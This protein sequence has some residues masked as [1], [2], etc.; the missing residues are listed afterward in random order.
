MAAKS[1][2]LR[3]VILTAEKT[4]QTAMQSRRATKTEKAYLK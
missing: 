3:F 1:M 4:S 2:G